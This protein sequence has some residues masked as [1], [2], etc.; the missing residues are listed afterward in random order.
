MEVIILDLR[1]EYVDSYELVSIYTNLGRVDCRYYRVEGTDKG[2]IMVG[3]IG[4]DFDT[5]ADNLYP[6]LCE[7]LRVIGISSLRVKFRHPTDLSESLLD[8]LIG[9]EFLKTEK[10]KAFGLIGHSFGGAVVVQAVSNDKNVKTVITLSTQ[11]FGI[12]PISFLPGSISVFLIH[13]KADE[14]LPPRNSVYGYNLAHEP[15]K[16]KLYEGAGHSLKE[17]SEEVYIDV[18][19][20]II[21][22]LK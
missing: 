19:S 7:Y 18:E 5:P 4:G 14:T 16:I 17:V 8:V 9:V 13:G 10:I 6:R 1:R 2:V 21:D 11:S 15:N 20:W 22:N 12:S 3:G